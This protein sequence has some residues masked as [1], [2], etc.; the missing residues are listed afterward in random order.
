MPPMP[1]RLERERRTVAARIR[2]YCRDRHGG[3]QVLC[4]ACA[5]LQR[6]T[7]ERVTH[8]VL[9][10]EKPTCATCAYRCYAPPQ[11]AQ[12]RAVMRYGGPRFFWRHPLLALWHCFDTRYTPAR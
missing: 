3:G 11:Q 6:Y 8:C 7:A 4:A 9:Y 12:I 1:P 5:E 2:I 10:P